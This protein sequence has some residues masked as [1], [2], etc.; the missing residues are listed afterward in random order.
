LPL[1]SRLW[2]KAGAL[3]DLRTLATNALLRAVQGRLRAIVCLQSLVVGVLLATVVRITVWAF[4]GHGVSTWIV[5]GLAGLA[6]GLAV[7]IR[8]WRWLTPVAVAAEIEKRAPGLDNLLVSAVELSRRSRAVHPVIVHEIERQTEARVQAIDPS[9][10]V[11]TTSAVA[12]TVAVAAGAALAAWSVGGVSI[13]ERAAMTQSAGGSASTARQVTLTVMVTPPAYTSL[14]M[15]T[16]RDV[17]E[18]EVLEG[19]RVRLAIEPATADVQL[20]EAGQVTMAFQRSDATRAVELVAERTRFLLLRFAGD[21][22]PPDRLLVLNV[23]PD[24]APIVRIRQPARDLVFS[25][26]RGRVAVEVEATDDL[27][28]GAVSLRYTRVFGSGESMTFQEGDLPLRIER[29][30][31]G[32]WRATSEISLEDLKLADGDTLVYRATTRDLRPGRDPST[33]D[34]YLLEVGKLAEVASAGFALPDDKD[35]Q[36]LSQQ[37][38]IVKTERLHAERGRL[39]SAE[40]EER[41]RTLAVEQRMVRAEF[42]FMT[43]GEVQDE[44]A[45]AEHSHDLTEGRF[46]NEGQVE[47]LTAIR[48][49]SRAEARL[50]DASTEQ[51][52]VFERAAL[53]ALQRAFDR[54]RYLLRTTPERARIDG[55]RRLT[56]ELKEALSWRRAP[57]SALDRRAM[58]Q[59][60]ALV[61]DV[62]AAQSAGK[63]FGSLAARLGAIDASAPDVQQAA[64]R[65]SAAATASAQERSAVVEDTLRLLADRARQ[66]LAPT[67][68]WVPHDPAAGRFADALSQRSAK[69]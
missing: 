4:G 41:S 65:L 14:P 53:K 61:R 39:S 28:L 30:E 9:A 58:E 46:E 64:L 57:A 38:V 13:A 16:V 67:H 23:K 33:S 6:I 44:V 37:M 17:N 7:M 29:S 35:R 27:A 56:G 50:N 3:P 20:V 31:R 66:S 8:G 11:P 48:E 18:V 34:A 25:E 63:D 19:S 15:T 40:F 12:L 42:V 60:E 59:L 54:R 10:L 22:A 62:A 32:R 26:P 1:R 21:D 68:T 2:A 24:A 5:G 69:P 36:A 47:L 55:T 51:A 43:G 52:L 45:E 49:M